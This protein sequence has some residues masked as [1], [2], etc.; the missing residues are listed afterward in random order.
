MTIG[1]VSRAI[2]SKNRTLRLAAQ[3][4]ASYDYIQAQLIIKGVAICLGDKSGFPSI[5]EV[6]PGLFNEVVQEHQDK[7]QEKKMELSALRFKQFAQS[8]NKDFKNKE[9]PK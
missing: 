3:E 9:V 4:K 5:Y 1:E 7:V 2:L 8:Y 6:Y